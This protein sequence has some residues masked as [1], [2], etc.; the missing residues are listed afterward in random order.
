MN[1]NPFKEWFFDHF[2]LGV[3]MNPKAIKL[4]LCAILLFDRVT[5]S[6]PFEEELIKGDILFLTANI[7][8]LHRPV[9]DRVTKLYCILN[10]IFLDIKMI[11]H[12]IYPTVILIIN[13]I[14][15]C[16]NI[17]MVL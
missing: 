17:F 9:S 11:S 8:S 3:E 2:A 6:H 5:Q 16:I 4:F 7:T 10:L 12:L 1:C 15:K 14:L 13:V